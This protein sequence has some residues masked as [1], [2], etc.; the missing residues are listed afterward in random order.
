MQCIVSLGIVRSVQCMLAWKGSNNLLGL[1]TLLG[2]DT[3]RLSVS[4]D[5]S[6]PSAKIPWLHHVAFIPLKSTECHVTLTGYHF[7]DHDY[8]WLRCG[9]SPRS[10]PPCFNPFTTVTL[11]NFPAP[12]FKHLSH[13]IRNFRRARRFY[14]LKVTWP[15]E[16]GSLVNGTTRAGILATPKAIVIDAYECSDNIVLCLHVAISYP[17]FPLRNVSTAELETIK[18]MCQL[19]D[20]YDRQ[21]SGVSIYWGE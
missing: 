6:K 10:I 18:E 16:N 4:V 11:R 9:A 17:N 8:L 7:A 5:G 14:F 21:A 1:N 12:S 2:R 20:H 3:M 15:L 13:A 19:I